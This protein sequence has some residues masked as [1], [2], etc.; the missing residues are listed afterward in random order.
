MSLVAEKLPAQEGKPQLYKFYKLVDA[1]D[2]D[3][4]TVQVRQ[5]RPEISTKE[6]LEAVPAQVDAQSAAVKAQAAEKLAAIAA[7]G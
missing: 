3:G 4:A 5:Y 1:V 6:Q 2:A 7:L